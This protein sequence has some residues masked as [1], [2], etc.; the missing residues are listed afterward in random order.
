MRDS[1]RSGLGSVASIACL[2]LA[3]GGCARG[4]D[5]ASPELPLRRVVVYRNGVG[6]FERGGAVEGEQV[7]FK[8]RQR[9][10]GDFLATLAI[11]ERGGSS[12]KAAS[13]PLEVDKDD[14]ATQDPR[15]AQM[16]AAW[17]RPGEPPQPPEPPSERLR[18]VLLRLDGKEH[19]LAVGYVAT[20]PL[21]RPSYR[22]VV[23]AGGADLQVWGIVQNLSGEDW[24]DVELTLVAGAPIAF[25]S[26]LG[27]AVTP[28]RPVITDT[29]EIIAQ[30]PV[31]MTT[32]GQQPGSSA[33]ERYAPVEAAAPA[34]EPAL[35]KDEATEYELN[36]EDARRSATSRASG[37]SGRGAAARPK[38]AMPAAAPAPAPPPPPPPTL[39]AS[40]E[41]ARRAAMDELGKQ[42]LSA[43][44]RLSALAAVA[45]GGGT[46]RYRIPGQVTV[47]DE[48]ATMV[49]LVSRKVPGESVF[50][51][52]PDSGVADSSAHPFRVV[53]FENATSGLLERGPIA[54]F[55]E[56]QFLGQGMLDPLPPKAKTTVPFALDRSVA[57]SS[58]RMSTEQ[59]ARLF[60]IE[61][62]AL[63][64]ERDSV[65]KTTYKVVNG[66]D[67]TS[68]LLIRHPRLGGARLFKPPAGTEDDLASASALV[69]IPLKPRGRAEL[70]V[71][72]RQAVQ[73]GMD[74]LHPLAE[75]A[76]R[77]YLADSRAD[78]GVAQKLTE[79]WVLR[80]AL[81]KAGEQVSA[82]ETEQQEL[83]KSSRETRLSLEAIEKNNQAADLRQKLTRRL[84]EV[85]LRLDQITK[86]L[87]ELRLSLGEAQVRFKEA[88]REVKLPGP[89]PPK[90]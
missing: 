84:A 14:P 6:Y 77:Q 33:V 75:E 13:F 86:K 20:T 36:D 34:A 18:K 50:L 55:G 23:G 38:K 28:A 35:E 72:E 45:V 58:E 49:L 29:G 32:L 4:P 8:M 78:R 80:D 61:A 71:D 26:T 3:F 27:D 51:F 2:A 64:I 24:K 37:G 53:R 16:L 90:D 63:Y 62:G 48:S 82:L 65:T 73:Q 59:G 67:E 7:S 66:G 60:R 22:V 56:G 57:V 68:K 5:V 21:W 17:N 10:V 44:R 11:V 9:M 88:I 25:E 40:R 89:L 43:P 85:T 12:L 19:D 15:F 30:V 81:K 52:S 41:Q 47:P 83:E 31:G 76:V 70:V 42:G 54:V 69:P 1:V 39:Q 79:A 46:T 87:V 74:W